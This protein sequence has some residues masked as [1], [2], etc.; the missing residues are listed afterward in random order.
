MRWDSL[1][2][3]FRGLIH[4]V[5]LPCCSASTAHFFKWLPITYSYILLDHSSAIA[6]SSC[7]PHFPC[8][9]STPVD[10]FMPDS[11]LLCQVAYYWGQICLQVGNLVQSYNRAKLTL[12]SVQVS[13]AFL[14]FE[15]WFLFLFPCTDPLFCA[16]FSCCTPANSLP[17]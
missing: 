1:W 14:T 6:L 7:F 13:A 16:I 10:I 2:R 8:P 5:F 11:L 9:F 3:Q 15:Y 4:L 17:H 12:G